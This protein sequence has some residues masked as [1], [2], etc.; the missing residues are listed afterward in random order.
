MAKLRFNKSFTTL[1]N[2]DH[3]SSQPSTSSTSTTYSTSTNNVKKKSRNPNDLSSQ[4][5]E[6]MKAP[7]YQCFEVVA[8]T[9]FYNVVVEMGISEN[10]LEVTPKSGS[11]SPSSHLTERFFSK[12]QSIKAMNIDIEDVVECHLISSS[13]PSIVFFLYHINRFDF[14]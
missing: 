9:K 2:L 7:L 6:I 14:F 4:M 5:F 1:S 10:K 12:F 3:H 11:R 13:K 8:I